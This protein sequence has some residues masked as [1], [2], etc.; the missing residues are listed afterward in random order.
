MREALSLVGLA[1][2]IP[3]IVGLLVAD[4]WLFR[5]AWRGRL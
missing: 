2:L 5:Y 1:L 4:W 3:A